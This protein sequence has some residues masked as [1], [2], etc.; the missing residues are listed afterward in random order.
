[1]CEAL[2]N[3]RTGMPARSG[4]FRCLGSERHDITCKQC[5]NPVSI[6]QQLRKQHSSLMVTSQMACHDAWSM[7]R[8]ESPSQAQTCP[9]GPPGRAARLEQRHG[10]Q[11]CDAAVGVAGEDAVREPKRCAQLH[12]QLGRVLQRVGAATAILLA[13]DRPRRLRRSSGSG[14]PGSALC[15]LMH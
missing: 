1:V 7:N 9:G 15:T 12:G 14:D 13:G 5:E 2:H 8:R 6:A 3:Q 10:N 11:R 4:R